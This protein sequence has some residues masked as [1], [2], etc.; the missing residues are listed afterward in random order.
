MAEQTDGA[1]GAGTYFLK[2]KSLATAFANPQNL[3]LLQVVNKSGKVIWNL[4][5]AGSANVNPASP[6]RDALLGRYVGDTFALAFEPNPMQ[7]DVFQVVGPGGVGI[8]HVDS[9]GAAFSD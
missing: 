9:S 4:T 6:T 3:D 7:Y 8:F 2:A 5:A 1:V